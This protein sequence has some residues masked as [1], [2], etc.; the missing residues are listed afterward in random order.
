MK[1]IIL[2]LLFGLAAIQVMAGTT[3]NLLKIYAVLTDK[4]VLRPSSLPELPATIISQIPKDKTNAVIFI[5]DQLI[6]NQLDVV[7]DGAKF[8]MILPAGWQSLPLAKEL[9]QSVTPPTNDVPA[10]KIPPGTVPPGTINFQGVRLDVFLEIY[11]K[12]R[13]RTVVQPSPL[14]DVVIDFQTQTPLTKNELIHAFDV[15][16]A[17]NGIATVDDG[18]K[19]VKVVPV[20]SAN[21][22][23]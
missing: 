3:D 14:P 13:G 5:E 11:S 21:R 8:V 15:I 23:Q 7:R 16:L 2:I 19:F 6:T 22:T 10:S 12:L 4:T 17:L 9:D 20:K 1:K 18:D